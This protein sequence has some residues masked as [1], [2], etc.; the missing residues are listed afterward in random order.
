MAGY[1]VP[2]NHSEEWVKNYKSAE[3]NMKAVK[4][5]IVEDLKPNR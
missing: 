1:E 3:E 2:E 4:E 5:K